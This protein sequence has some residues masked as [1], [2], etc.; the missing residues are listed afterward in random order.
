M[1][2]AY[3]ADEAD[4]CAHASGGDGLVGTFAA[5]EG[6]VSAAEDGFAGLRNA[7]DADDQVH[8]EGADDAD[9]RGGGGECGGRGGVGS[10]HGAV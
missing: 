10:G 6:A 3:A 7:R 8:V 5:G 9:A 4:E 1:V 2:K